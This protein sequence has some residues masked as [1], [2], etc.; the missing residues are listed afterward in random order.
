MAVI[1]GNKATLVQTDLIGLDLVQ[2]NA[3]G[4][5]QWQKLR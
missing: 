5:N 2:V 3:N 4:G 1:N